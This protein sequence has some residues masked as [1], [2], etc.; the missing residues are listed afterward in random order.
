MGRSPAKWIKSVILRKKSPKSKLSEGNDVLKPTTNK[1][2]LLVASEAPVSGTT[3]DHSLISQLAPAVGA[4]SVVNREHG[5][6]ANAPSEGLASSCAKASENGEGIVNSGVQDDA[7]RIRLQ[8]AAT[9][10]QSS[11]R[12]Y[13]AR[14]AFKKHKSSIIRLQAL[15]RGHLVRRQ[16][17][18]TL[19]CVRAVIKIQALARGQK[20]RRS[21]VGIEVQNAC[22]QGK[23]QGAAYFSEKCTYPMEE[24]LIK[25]VFAQK[26]FASSPRAMPLSL[27]Y[28]LGDPNSS[29]EW[30]ERWTES[31]FW[32]SHSRQKSTAKHGALKKVETK[33]GRTRRIVRNHSHATAENCSGS[34]VKESEKPK[35]N[36]R[37]VGHP[38]DSVQ[39]H[40]KIEV[41]K[42]NRNSRKTSNPVKEVHERLNVV[43]GKAKR[44]IRKSSVVRTPEVSSGTNDV[45]VAVTRDSDADKSPKLA[46]MDGNVTPLHESPDLDLQP[47]GVNSKVDDI[48]EATEQLSLTGGNDESHDLVLQPVGNNSRVDDIQGKSKPL[49]PKD[50]NSGNENQKINERRASLPP[51]VEH[52]ENG[53]HSTPKVPSYMAPTE[54][55]RAKLRAQG[56]PRFS[57]DAIESI[58]TTR[59]HSLP[60]STNARLA[61]MS[62]RAHK[63]V[64]SAGKGLVSSNRS[65][66]SSRDGNDKAMKAEW[67]R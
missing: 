12:G 64:H 4:R 40:P 47:L 36:Q 9:K 55:A 29:R 23:I 59:R 11:F 1:G 35:P 27:Q 50:Y 15:V 53:V 38:V 60:S 56:S 20:V 32:L 22:N 61:S 30:L 21:A 5:E 2:E 66:S 65:L 13:Q 41:E 51:N 26:L 42:V 67:R 43:S 54:S 19:C 8:T 63:L 25:N 39:E 46:T 48:Q 28:N 10:A 45:A 62:P 3:T 16:A 34:S 58:A 57:Q 33:Q 31:Q 14:R 44:T 18:T 37:K 49:N 52:V 6:A 24:K 17:V 7:D